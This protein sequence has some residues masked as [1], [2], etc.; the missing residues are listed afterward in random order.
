MLGLLRFPNFTESFITFLRLANLAHLRIKTLELF[1]LPVRW[2]FDRALLRHE[3]DLTVSIFVRG[4]VEY[5]SD[6]ITH[7]HVVSSPARIEQNAIAIFRGAI[8]KRDQ[9]QFA[10]SLQQLVDLSFHRDA[11]FKFQL[12]LFAFFEI[13][14]LSNAARRT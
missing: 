14:L 1:A 3:R 7:S 9:K 2:N 10:I 12:R 11:A 8:R 5:R 6:P 13:G 4:A